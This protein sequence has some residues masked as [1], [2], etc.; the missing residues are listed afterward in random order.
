MKKVCLLIM[1]A[2]AT[3]SANQANAQIGDIIAEIMDDFVDGADALACGIACADEKNTCYIDVMYEWTN[4][5]WWCRDR[6]ED[7]LPYVTYYYEACESWCEYSYEMGV[8]A[9]Y[10]YYDLCLDRC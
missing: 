7:E 6:F 2:V 5:Y 3:I 4:C 9:C 1:I 10:F 8:D